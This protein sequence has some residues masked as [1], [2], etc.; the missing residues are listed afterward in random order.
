MNK[1]EVKEWLGFTKA[2]IPVWVSA[3]CLLIM[4]FVKQP[5]LDWLLAVI[6]LIL[7]VIA[8]FAGMKQDE[9]LSKVT[10][11]AKKFSYP[12]FVFIVVLVTFLNFKFLAG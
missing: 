4:I 6:S 7:S 9:S 2:D 1:N 11:L 10:N 12:L 5:V 3:T 8:C